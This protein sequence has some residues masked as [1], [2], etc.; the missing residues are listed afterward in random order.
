MGGDSFVGRHI[1]T[2]TALQTGGSASLVS[3]YII[4]QI[5]LARRKANCQCTITSC[6]LRVSYEEK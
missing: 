3:L 6:E 1:I 2:H 4:I 5:P